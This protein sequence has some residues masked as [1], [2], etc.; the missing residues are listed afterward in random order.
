M[1]RRYTTAEFIAKA[2]QVHG[3]KYDYSRVHYVDSVTPV[4]IICPEHGEFKQRPA[5]HLTGTGCPSCGYNKVRSVLSDTLEVFLEK[6]RKVHGDKYDYSLVEYQGSE[7]KIRIVCPEHGEFLQTPNMHLRGRRCPTCGKNI[8]SEKRKKGLDFFLQ[9]AH[10]VHGDRYDYSKVDLIRR[11]QKVCIICKK[12]GEFWQSPHNHTVQKQGCPICAREDNAKKLTKDTD[13]FLK[14]AHAIHGDKYDY[15][16]TH[17]ISARAKV[18]IIC[19][20][21]DDGGQEHGR[22]WMGPTYHINN[23]QGCPKCAHPKHTLN[24]FINQAK[25]KYGDKF[26]YSKTVYTNNHS[27]LTVTC[28][29]HGDFETFPNP[30]LRGTGCPKC[31]GRNLTTDEFVELA[32][33]IHGDKYDYSKVD[34]KNRTTPIRIVCPEHGE[35]IQPPYRHLNGTGCPTCGSLH[36]RFTQEEFIQKAREVHGDAYD[37]SKADYRG[38]EIPVC[39]VCPKH[40]EFYQS[41]HSHLNGANCPKCSGRARLTKESFI[42]RATRLHNGKFDYSKVIIKGNKK[43]VCI[44]CPEHGEFWQTPNA[45]LLG[46][47]CSK[48]AGKYM[49]QTMFL[50]RA[51]LVHGNKYDYS[52]AHYVNSAT[53]VRIICPEHGVFL[54]SAASHLAGQRCPKCSGKYMDTEYFIEKCTKKHH[55][56]YDYSLVEYKGSHVKVKIICPQHG[57]FE[58]KAYLHLAGNGC[59]ICNQSHLEAQVR[60]LLKREK[61]KFIS[62]QQFDW[63]VYKDN[64]FLDFFIPKYGVAIECQGEQHFRPLDFFGGKEAFVQAIERDKMKRRLC[65]GHNIKILYFSD[66]GIRYPYPVI[67]EPKQ[68]LDAIYAHGEVDSSIWEDPE[69]PLSFG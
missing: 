42:E 54:Q 50:E 24:W 39:I 3:N 9:Q 30:F 59:P 17:Y 36:N 1:T 5:L 2:K 16:E 68:L 6:A 45:H 19:H 56:K 4:S 15:S 12:H 21:K 65:K 51:H 22:F 69:L 61:L 49:D 46:V 48:C 26:D 53:K 11:D 60:G 55:G 23:K 28:P 64:L 13:W 58:Q 62:Q 25:T 66:L 29:Q 32:R 40:G 41:P 35:F 33:L 38:T 27:K 20:E 47:G 44:I 31:E 67:E 37:Y 43:K 7:K 57:V 34:Y 8:S 52:E 18:C 10:E 63:L 14:R